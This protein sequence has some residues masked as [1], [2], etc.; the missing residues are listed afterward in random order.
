[1]KEELLNKRSI[2]EESHQKVCQFY[3]VLG[4]Y[5]Q[6]FQNNDEN[7]YF[8]VSGNEDVNLIQYALSE[9]W[10]KKRKENIEVASEIIFLIPDLSYEEMAK[11]WM[12][13]LNC[14]GKF[15]VVKPIIKESKEDIKKEE[16]VQDSTDVQNL[17]R[18]EYRK[19]LE[20]QVEVSLEVKEEKIVDNIVQESEEEEVKKKDEHVFYGDFPKK[21]MELKNVGSSSAVDYMWGEE[22]S[23]N[24]MLN[25]KRK[26]DVPVII[27]IVSFVV[28][29]IAGILLFIL[30]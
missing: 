29:V 22:K 21:R 28:L 15:Q 13:K 2:G 20:Q 10:K 30:K 9:E 24:L 7:R 5:D 17:S 26:L 27:F 14:R 8:M 1:M 11:E 25:K 16:D 18:E 19:E 12:D 23:K 6:V 3:I 4:H